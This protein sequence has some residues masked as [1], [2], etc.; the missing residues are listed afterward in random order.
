V[1]NNPVNYIDPTGHRPDD[2]SQ[3]DYAAEKKQE[4]ERSRAIDALSSS[5]SVLPAGIDSKT[6]EKFHVS[7]YASEIYD[8]SQAYGIPTE[9]IGAMMEQE[10]HGDPLANNSSTH[11]RGESC[12]DG[13]KG[14]MQVDLGSPAPCGNEGQDS[15]GHWAELPG[16]TAEEKS[17]FLYNPH[18]N[19][20][21]AVKNVLLPAWTGSGGNI[22]GTLE[23]YNGFGDPKYVPSVMEYYNRL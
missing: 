17:D 5:L 23:G 9:L 14:L 22:K 6:G 12:C 2:M 10:S 21:W 20:D 19:V 1:G 18:N 15:C 11:G 3:A 7:D 16:G 4:G 13:G 8:A